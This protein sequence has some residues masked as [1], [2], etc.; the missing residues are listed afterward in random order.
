MNEELRLFK[1]LNAQICHEFYF[2]G[3]TLILHLLVASCTLNSSDI[4]KMC[5]SDIKRTDRPHIHVQ[6]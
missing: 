6:R 5:L 1:R 3:K 4:W 2:E